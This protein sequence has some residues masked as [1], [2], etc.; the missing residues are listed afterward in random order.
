[1]FAKFIA[2]LPLVCANAAA[3]PIPVPL[4]PWR[5]V[6]D[7]SALPASANAIAQMNMAVTPNW[8]VVTGYLVGPAGGAGTFIIRSPDR[9]QTWEP[10]PAF[11]PPSGFVTGGVMATAVGDTAFIIFGKP[12][13]VR[14]TD[15]GTTVTRLAN[16]PPCTPSAIKR[17]RAALFLVCGASAPVQLYR[18]D[19]GGHTWA[20]IPETV[21]TPRFLPIPGISTSLT[22]AGSDLS[23]PRAARII[24]STDDGRS[25]RDPLPG[26]NCDPQ[27]LTAS[28]SGLAAVSCNY[29]GRPSPRFGALYTTT[30][31]GASWSETML[32]ATTLD[33]ILEP[34]VSGKELFVIVRAQ[35]VDPLVF[36]SLL[37]FAGIEWSS[38]GGRTWK[39]LESPPQTPGTA[40]EQFLELMGVIDNE[41]WVS[42][43]PRIYARSFPAMSKQGPRGQPEK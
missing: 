13:L 7:A 27:Y 43:G 15:G 3:Q 34:Y 14:T 24:L 38:D 5:V 36:R 4:S 18:S 22:V 28:D 12:W 33:A 20:G 6:Y 41:L 19:D 31:N 17:G 30:D 37:Q 32:P 29:A 23:N 2:L 10:V 11:Q 8:L 9:G 1:M 40:Y 16:L 21:Q 39:N 25:W 35:K 42:Q 26:L